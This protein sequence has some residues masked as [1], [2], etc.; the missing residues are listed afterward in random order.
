MGPFY[1]ILPNS[2]VVDKPSVNIAVLLDV[3]PCLWKD[4]ETTYIL[5]FAMELNCHQIS[6]LDFPLK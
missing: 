6:S 2:S 3:P 4:R 5:S 1:G